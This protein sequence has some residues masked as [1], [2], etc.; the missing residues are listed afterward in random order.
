MTA[1][2]VPSLR[3]MARS[4]LALA[5]LGVLGGCVFGGRGQPPRFGNPLLVNEVVRILNV[6]E[7]SPAYYR[8][9]GRLEGLGP[10]LDAVLVALVENEDADDHVRLQVETGI[11]S[12]RRRFGARCRGR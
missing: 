7:P 5:G 12:H 11:A 2:R 3:R 8:E 9:R 6:E 10:E 4:A 1:R